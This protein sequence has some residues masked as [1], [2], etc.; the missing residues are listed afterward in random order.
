MQHSPL[1][2]ALRILRLAKLLSLLRLFRLSRLLRYVGEWEKVPKQSFYNQLGLY[3]LS[4]HRKIAEITFLRN[5]NQ[6]L[7]LA[8]SL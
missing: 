7:T 8:H 2:Q 6:F 4:L 1:G 5:E 3:S